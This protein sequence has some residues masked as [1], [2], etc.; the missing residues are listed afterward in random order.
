[1]VLK[2]RPTSRSLKL[3]WSEFPY[4]KQCSTA[5]NPNEHTTARSNDSKT[6]LNPRARQTTYTFGYN[7][8]NSIVD[9]YH[10]YPKPSGLRY[11][12]GSRKTIGN[13][14][15]DIVNTVAVQECLRKDAIPMR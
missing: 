2:Q 3:A 11:A 5:N 1:M 12:F 8:W 4:A 10:A 9:A 14:N 6:F 15:V 13:G 7:N